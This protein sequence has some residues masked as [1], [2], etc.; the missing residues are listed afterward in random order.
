MEGPNIASK[1]WLKKFAKGSVGSEDIQGGADNKSGSDIGGSRS[2]GLG[3]GGFKTSKAPSAGKKVAVS[4]PVAPPKK[5]K[6]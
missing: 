3:G 6:R 5:K 2:G 1:K 4:K